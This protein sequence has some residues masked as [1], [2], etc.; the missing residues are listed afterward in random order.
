[1]LRNLGHP[2]AAK[3]VELL[4]ARGASKTVI[5]VAKDYRCVPCL[6]Y[7]KPNQA[8]PAAMP[9][10]STFNVVI[11][12]DVMWLKI[13][14]YPVLH[15]I[16]VANKYQAACVVHGERSQDLQKALQRTWFRQF[17]VPAE[18]CTDE[19]RGW[20]ADEMLGYFTDLNLKHTVSPGEAHQKLGLVERYHQVLRKAAE[21]FMTD[22]NDV[23]L[24][25]SL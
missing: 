15:V 1:M 13:L 12:A 9:T 11:E 5:N 24:K 6:R 2:S 22:R 21:V 8:S 19:G 17:G 3:L 10:A 20:A 14:E 4:E 18:L 23:S 25:G 16:D 7:H